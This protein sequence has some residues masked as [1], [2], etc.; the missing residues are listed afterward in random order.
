MHH[1]SLSIAMWIACMLLAACNISAPIVTPTAEVLVSNTPTSEVTLTSTP[2]LTPS[3]TSRPDEVDVPVIVVTIEDNLV[4]LPTDI[5]TAT[6][7][8]GACEVV[9]IEGDT[10]IQILSRESCGNQRG[11]AL[12]DAVVALNDN[13]FD[14][15]ILPPVGESLLIPRPTPTP[16]PEGIEMTETA[17]AERGVRVLGNNEFPENTV[18]DCHIVEEGESAIGIAERYNST[19]VQL[20][21]LNQDISWPGCDFTNPSGG[22]NCS[23]QISI[24]QCVVVPFP[25]PTAV[26]TATPSG[27]ETATPTATFAPARAIWPPEGVSASPGRLELS[28]VSVGILPPNTMYLIEVADRTVNTINNYITDNTT[29]TLPDDLIPSDGQVH[30]MEWRVTVARLNTDGSY[31]PIGG[32]GNWR[33]FQWQSR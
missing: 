32:L 13:L 7:T 14:A 9:I 29:F 2:S 24:G 18:F 10:L 30:R 12:I 33:G 3:S 19:L 28:W 16:I 31:S 1:V 21:L 22:V 20:S 26:P 23:P 25:T 8:P 11:Q 17:A 5:S 15:D 4:S 6:P 27:N